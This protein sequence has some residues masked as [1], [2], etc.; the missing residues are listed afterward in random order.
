VLV[1]EDDPEQREALGELLELEGLDV[2]TASQA[3]EVLEEL[4]RSPDLVLLDL[5]GVSSPEVVRALRTRA[6][7]PAVVVVSADPN[8]ARRAR[9]LEAD[10]HVAKPYDVNQLLGVIGYLLGRA[11]PAAQRV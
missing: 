3:S 6:P 1:C 5:V 10:G 11:T 8:L 4:E 2:C 9:E 7:R